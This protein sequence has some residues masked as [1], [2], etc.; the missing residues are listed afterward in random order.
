MII[1]THAHV[2]PGSLIET[3]RSEQRLFP[4]VRL[5][6]EA[7]S[8][9]MAFA[10]EAPTRPIV[11]RLSDLDQRREW[12]TSAGVDHQVVG[13]WTDVYG[14]EL[15]GDEGADWARFFNEHL[16]NDAATLAALTPLATVPLQDGELAARV[17]EEALDEGFKGAMIGT[18]PKGVGG[19]LDDPKLDPFWEVASARR[20]T[21]FLH[22]MYI[23]GDERLS[24]Y[25]LLNAVG[26][27]T[28]TTIAMARLFFSG[29]LTRHP[30][31]LAWRRRVALRARPTAPQ[32][33]D[34][35]RV[36]RSARRLSAA[37]FR[38]RLVRSGGI[39]F[40]LRCRRRGQ[41]GA[42]LRLPVSNR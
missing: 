13:G 17:L 32:P 9:R 8:F 26:R 2:V 33:G 18:Q 42:R 16:T 25:D 5:L 29:H 3:L 10:G 28:D 22:P 41:G 21:L 23:C 35:C 24:G 11:P 40:S 1:D 34:P 37:L 12:L 14:Y 30:C 36:P 6:R 15:S 39:A 38:H 7:G 27:L 31:R 19:N 4:S 20:A